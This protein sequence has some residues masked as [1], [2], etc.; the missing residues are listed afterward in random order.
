MQSGLQMFPLVGYFVS[1][2]L[3]LALMSE[4]QKEIY[5]PFAD[6]PA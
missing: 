3:L 2:L 1:S 4:L 6:V 5:N